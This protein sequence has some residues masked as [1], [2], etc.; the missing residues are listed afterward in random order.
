MVYHVQSFDRNH[1]GTF[2]VEVWDR[3]KPSVASAV[4]GGGFVP[5]KAQQQGDKK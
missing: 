1:I 3:D 4:P 5:L 2:K